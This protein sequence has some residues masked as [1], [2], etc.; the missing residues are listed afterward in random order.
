MLLNKTSMNQAAGEEVIKLK[1]SLCKRDSKTL[2]IY[3]NYVKLF[4]ICRNEVKW[5]PCFLTELGW[6][7]K[8][9]QVILIILVYITSILLFFYSFFMWG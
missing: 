3:I 9:I 7:Y 8:N 1:S 4:T 5:S 2:M 6:S